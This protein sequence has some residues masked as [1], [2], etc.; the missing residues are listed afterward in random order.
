MKEKEL[1]EKVR[2]CLTSLG[3]NL[4]GEMKETPRRIVDL[5]HDMMEGCNID[6]KRFFQRPLQVKHD[7]MV[8]I[9]NIEFVSWCCHHLWP[10]FG[11]VHIAF[12]PR[13]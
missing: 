7:E 6:L 9:K 4:N 2:D 1:Q 3:F 12:I 5:Y 8:V 13:G 10:F 11:K